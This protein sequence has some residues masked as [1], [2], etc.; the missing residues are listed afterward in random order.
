[1]FTRW[2]SIQKR[3]WKVIIV[4]TWRAVFSPQGRPLSFKTFLIWVLISIYQGKEE[5]E[6]VTAAVGEALNKLNK[7]QLYTQTHAVRSTVT[8]NIL[9]H[10]ITTS[11]GAFKHICPGVCRCTRH[12]VRQQDDQIKPW[13]RSKRRFLAPLRDTL[14]F[15]SP[16]A[17]VAISWGVNVC[18]RTWFVNK[19]EATFR[20][21]PFAVKR[22]FQGHQKQHSE[23]PFFSSPVKTWTFCFPTDLKPSNGALFIYRSSVCWHHQFLQL[24][25]S[26][27]LLKKKEQDWWW[28]VWGF[29][30]E[31]SLWSGEKKIYNCTKPPKST[32]VNKRLGSERSKII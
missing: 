22:C 18:V 17:F 1:M 14:L 13:Q 26:F 24:Y 10:R 31:L 8:A 28:Q 25:V 15:N 9:Y 12:Q 6:S 30:K 29:L 2:L 7:N 11:L 4:K 16:H 23:N 32:E 21:G 5:S 19:P 27:C 20:Q 3:V